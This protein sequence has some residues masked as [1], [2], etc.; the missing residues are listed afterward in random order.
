MLAEAGASVWRDPVDRRVVEGVRTRTGKVI[1]TQAEVGGWPALPAGK[2]AKDRDGDG[3]PDAWERAHGLNPKKTG[4]R[5]AGQGTA[6][7]GRT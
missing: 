1:N 3:M 5:A 7:A 6:Q 2:P 4:R